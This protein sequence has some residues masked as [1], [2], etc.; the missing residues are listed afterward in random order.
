MSS[1]VAGVGGDGVGRAVGGTG[2]GTG[3]AGGGVGSGWM[4]KHWSDELHD[5][6]FCP[7]LNFKE[8]LS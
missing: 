3:V 2:V 4:H 8:L 6:V 7:V 1:Q 5:P